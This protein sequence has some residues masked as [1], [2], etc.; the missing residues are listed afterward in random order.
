MPAR[1]L[2]KEVLALPVRWRYYEGE[3]GH[4]MFWTTQPLPSGSWQGSYIALLFGPDNRLLQQQY[5]E[6]RRQAKA[7]ALRWHRRYSPGTHFGNFTIK[8][9]P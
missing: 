2:P 1:S 5:A 6:L 7:R 9:Q 8:E 3:H 4:L